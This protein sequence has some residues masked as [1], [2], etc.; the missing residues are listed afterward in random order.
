MAHSITDMMP[1]TGRISP[2]KAS[3]PTNDELA[4]SVCKSCLESTRR[5][6]AM[7]KSRPV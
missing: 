2:F 1:R 4:R 5:P 6:M 7:A 3:S